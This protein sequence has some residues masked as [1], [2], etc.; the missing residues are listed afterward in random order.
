MA[1]IID[2]VKGGLQ[3]VGDELKDLQFDDVKDAGSYVL[4]ET[5]ANA[6]QSMSFGFTLASALAW[7]EAI[8]M[9]IK[10]SL[11]T[12]SAGSYFKYALAV[13]FF[14]TLVLIVTKKVLKKKVKTLKDI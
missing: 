6:L 1:G 4:E 5:W 11:K 2:D 8:K 10:K 7:N 14:T 12:D 9:Y 13:T 3:T